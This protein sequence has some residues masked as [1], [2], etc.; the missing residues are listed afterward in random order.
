M[1]VPLIIAGVPLVTDTYKPAS[2]HRSYCYIFDNSNDTRHIELAEKL[3]LWDGP[4]IIMLMVASVFMVVLVI[5]MVGLLWRKLKYEPISGGDRYWTALKELLPLTA[6]PILFF[7]CLIPQTVL[8]IYTGLNPTH[9]E[10]LNMVI[11]A[12]ICISLWSFASGMTLIIHLSLARRFA[13]KKAAL[14][15]SRRTSYTR[16]TYGSA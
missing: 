2:P 14:L 16:S 9:E 3:G 10:P 1:L 11:V 15:E 4:A 6:F 12:L 13:K 8:H 7:I 5:R